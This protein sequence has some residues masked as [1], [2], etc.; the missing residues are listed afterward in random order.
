M[1][2][3]HRLMRL[4]DVN[5]P[6]RANDLSDDWVLPELPSFRNTMRPSFC[7]VGH[8]ILLLVPGDTVVLL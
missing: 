4:W 7:Q 5:S 3:R 1:K 8:V 2:E 6:F